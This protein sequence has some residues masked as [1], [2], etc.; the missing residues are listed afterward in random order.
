M[1]YIKCEFQAKLMKNST[2]TT[3]ILQYAREYQLKTSPVVHFKGLL[4]P[5]FGFLLP[6][7]E[8]VM[9]LKFNVV[10]AHLVV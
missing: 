5:L 7:S 6:G 8:L 3:F 9:I 1:L 10:A 4:D 2:P